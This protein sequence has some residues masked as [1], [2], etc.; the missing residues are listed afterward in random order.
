VRLL[1]P[2]LLQVPEQGRIRDKHWASYPG[3]GH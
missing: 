1:F 2:V 3:D